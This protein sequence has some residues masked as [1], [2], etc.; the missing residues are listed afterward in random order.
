MTWEGYPVLLLFTLSY[1]VTWNDLL[2]SFETGG[3]SRHKD[4]TTASRTF[5]FSHADANTSKDQR[6]LLL[7]QANESRLTKNKTEPS[8][9]NFYTNPSKR[10]TYGYSG[11]LFGERPGSTYHPYR[12]HCNESTRSND[13]V[14]KAPSQDR[15]FYSMVNSSSTKR[16]KF[17]P[18]RPLV[19]ERE[20][21]GS[22][23]HRQEN[24]LAPFYGGG[25][26]AQPLYK[27]FP[28]YMPH[29]ADPERGRRRKR[30]AQ[31][32]QRRAWRPPHC[33]FTKPC[34]TVILRKRNL[35][36]RH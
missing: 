9:P 22:H 8:K 5:A 7:K 29:S 18:L 13:P 1:I 28:E 2:A 24:T 17:L 12:G 32:T 35:G 10:G 15:P 4:G 31:S 11:L 36:W 20:T 21:L 30:A 6:R 3:S 26:S 27:G 23:K 33:E 34:S 25:V 19:N 16:E 14:R